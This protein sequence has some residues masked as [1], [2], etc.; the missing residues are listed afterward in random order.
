[1][2]EPLRPD[3]FQG[4]APLDLIR[5]TWLQG[6]HEASCGLAQMVLRL[7]PRGEEPGDRGLLTAQGRKLG[8]YVLDS[9]FDSCVAWPPWPI[10]YRRLIL[11]LPI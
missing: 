9:F 6:L 5:M 11:C 10:P 8:V 7:S 2:S 4:G 1:M 3:P